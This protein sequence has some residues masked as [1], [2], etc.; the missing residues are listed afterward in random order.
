MIYGYNGILKAHL[1][2]M[3]AFM[4]WGLSIKNWDFLSNEEEGFMMLRI[5]LMEKYMEVCVESGWGVN[6]VKTFCLSNE[7]WP[8]MEIFDGDSMGNLA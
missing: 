4:F 1:D 5:D 3:F 2:W 8:K 7:E 6:R